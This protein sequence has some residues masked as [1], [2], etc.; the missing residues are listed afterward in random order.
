MRCDVGVRR[1]ALDTQTAHWLVPIP[2]LHRLQP[3]TVARLPQRLAEIAELDRAHARHMIAPATQL[4]HLV[5]RRAARP[6]LLACEFEH[7]FLP[8]IVLAPVPAAGMHSAPAAAACM[9]PAAWGWTRQ[10]GGEIVLAAR[11]EEA[12]AGRLGT[13]HAARSAEFHILH[14]EH[15]SQRRRHESGEGAVKDALVATARREERLVARGDL[16]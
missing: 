14:G 12:A 10:H 3:G 6:P 9:G 15:V 8:R 4:D 7:S 16:D 5:A 1:T 11:T 13:V 2:Q